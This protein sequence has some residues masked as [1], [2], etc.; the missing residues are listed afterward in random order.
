MVLLLIDL[1]CIPMALL[2]F[3]AVAEV[4]AAFPNKTV[5]SSITQCLPC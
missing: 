4:I 3:E 1:L 5:K 2:H